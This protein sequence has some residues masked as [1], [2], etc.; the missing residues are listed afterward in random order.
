MLPDVATS[1]RW[2]TFLHRC[3]SQRVDVEEFKSLSKLMLV[4]SPVKEYELLDLLLQTRAAS[5]VA[6]DPLL[7]VYVDGLCKVGQVK[8]SA[9][10]MSLLKHSSIRSNTES[11]PKTSTLMTDIKV[12]QDVMMAVSTGAIPRTIAEAADLFAANIEWIDAVVSWYNESLD[13]M[14]QSSGLMNNPDAVSL[15]E[16]V[17]ILLAALFNT[18]KGLDALTSTWIDRAH[19][20]TV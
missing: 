19:Q 20:G 8:P 14:Q 13:I 2:R 18:T 9:A 7:P 15:F 10:L 17:G 1:D 4:R 11:K 6:W 5:S 16:S 12:I 3:L